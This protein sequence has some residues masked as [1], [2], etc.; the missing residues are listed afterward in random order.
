MNHRQRPRLWAARTRDHT[1]YIQ[2]ELSLPSHNPDRLRVAAISFLNPAPLL[3]NFEHEPAAAELRTRYDV[4]YTLPSLCAAQLASGE[5]DLG[6]VPIAALPGLPDA[7]AVPGCTIA[8]LQAVRSIQLVLR[9]GVTLAS[10]QTVAADTASR[11]SV[12]YVQILLQQFYGNRPEFKQHP[13]DLEAM[14]QI[15]D[16]A[17]LIGDPALLAL[18]DRDT[19]SRFADCTWIDVASLWRQH[20]GLPWVAAV[21]AVRPAALE[22]CGISAADLSADL[23]ASRDA[24]LRH[25]D[26]L[27]DEWLPRLPL[28]EATIRTYLT[29]NI[30]YTLDTM[31]LQAIERFYQ[32]TTASGVLPEYSLQ[33]L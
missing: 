22:R 15:H 5:A 30:H 4:R 1:V 20:T 12:A 33:L 19:M 2:Y 3:W 27:V 21:W 23:A 26:D 14:L 17:L 16:A 28:S 8:S 32:L 25:T 31:C 29:Q 6:L 7:K 11:S 18:E 10:V 24:G 9:P 13:A